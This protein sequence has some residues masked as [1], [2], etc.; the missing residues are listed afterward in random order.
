M[1]IIRIYIFR[2]N[3]ESTMESVGSAATVMTYC[4]VTMNQAAN[5]PMES[6]Q[7]HTQPMKARYRLQSTFKV[8]RADISNFESVLT[9]IYVGQSHRIVWIVISCEFG[10]WTTRNRAIDII[11]KVPENSTY[12]LSYHVA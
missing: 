8:F 7:T 9:T 3:T 12:E 5:S 6:S 10:M 4:H 2:Y 1:T 11:R